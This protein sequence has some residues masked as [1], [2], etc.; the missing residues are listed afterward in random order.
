MN[1]NVLRELSD[2]GFLRLTLNH[3][4]RRNAP[5]EAMLDELGSMLG[6]ASALHSL[7]CQ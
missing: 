1:T 2:E 5:S 7:K 6:K 3:P 4:D